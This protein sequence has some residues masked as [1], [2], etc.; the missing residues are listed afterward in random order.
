MFKLTETDHITAGE[1]MQVG[2]DLVIISG[3]V[4]MFVSLVLSIY[5]GRKWYKQDV[6]L[7]TDL[8][9]VFAIAMVCNTLNALFLTLPSIGVL[10]PS[11][12]LFRLRS[13]AIG[14]AVIPVW[15]ALLQIWAS[16]YEK[17]HNRTVL[18]L[19][20]YWFAVALLGPSEA[21]IMSLTIPLL[22]I[23][24]IAMMG[25]FVITWKTGRLKEVRSEL[26]VLSMFFMLVSQGLRVPLMLTP[27]FYIPDVILIASMVFLGFGFGNPW[28]NRDSKKASKDSRQLV[29]Y[30]E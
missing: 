12:N 6:R 11:L 29:Q 20:I 27:L 19:S 28:Q 25:T 16:K 13:I 3:F 10:E 17:Y 21:F 2:T 30:A 4:T 26:L 8:P 18:L 9:L 23:I 14:G 24:S 1:N 15:G 5:L 7:M 22:F